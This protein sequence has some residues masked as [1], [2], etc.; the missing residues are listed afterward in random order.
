[1]PICLLHFPGADTEA[2]IRAEELQL[3]QA[4]ADVSAGQ[5]RLRD[6]ECLLVDMTVGSRTVPEAER[7][8][9]LLK[10]CLV[11][12]ERH[13]VLIEQRLAYL[14]ERHRREAQS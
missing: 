2:A 14:K 8:V 3:R 11:E 4:K 10:G 13:R 12:W 7:F 9:A 5:A 1:M 6:Q